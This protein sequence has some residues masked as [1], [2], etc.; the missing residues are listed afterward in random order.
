LR[1]QDTDLLPATK[2]VRVPGS[3]T[4]A[5][6]ATLPV[7]DAL[8][9]WVKAAVP[10]PLAYKWLREYWVRTAAG[11]GDVRLHDLRHFPAQLLVNAGR[12]EASVQSTMRHASPAMTR[13]YAGSATGARTPRCWRTCFWRPGPSGV[14]SHCLSH[15]RPRPV[16]SRL[17]SRC[18]T[19]SGGRTRTDDPRIMIPLL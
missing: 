12:S 7:A 10:S 19:S 5:S 16:G 3:K 15:C 2:Q 1:L 9:P 8:W 11:A 6:A 14:R 4:A 13:R 18:A 17:L